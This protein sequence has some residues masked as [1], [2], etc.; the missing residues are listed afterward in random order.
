MKLLLP[1]PVQVPVAAPVAWINIFASV[2]LKAALVNGTAFGLVMVKST[3]LVPPSEIVGVTNTLTIVGALAFTVK[4]AVLDAAPVAA[5]ALATP[6]VVFGNIP[7]VL[8]VTRSVMV[9]LPAAGIVSPAK[10]SAPV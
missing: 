9:Q 5:S 3:W 1:A 10:L 4:V 2:S 8:D 7:G 6:L